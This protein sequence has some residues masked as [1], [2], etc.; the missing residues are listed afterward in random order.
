MMKMEEPKLNITTL[1]L[2]ELCEWGIVEV[3]IDF[4]KLQDSGI[5][6]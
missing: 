4:L 6:Q 3:E 5:S 2:D 1:K